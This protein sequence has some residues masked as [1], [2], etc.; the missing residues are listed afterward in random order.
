MQR[1]QTCGRG[2]TQN[3]FSLPRACQ[4]SRLRLHSIR[5]L[6]TG[7][8]HGRGKIVFKVELRRPG[9]H[10][11]TRCNHDQTTA[12]GSA[13]AIPHDLIPSEL[14]GHLVRFEL[15]DGGTIFL[16]DVGELS[17]DTH[18]ADT[19]VSV[20]Q[21]RVC[22]TARFRTNA[23]TAS[24]IQ[25]EPTLLGQ[26]VVVIGGSAGI[27][28]FETTRRDTRGEGEGNF[29]WPESGALQGAAI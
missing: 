10:R 17:P 6:I 4:S 14:F 19:F 27:A 18:I 24:S 9:K 8:S 13:A 28:S 1:R 16:D 22:F 23:T 29:H 12:K 20:R 7:R 15:A 11:P 26:T 3:L 2:A 25:R 21:L 5:T